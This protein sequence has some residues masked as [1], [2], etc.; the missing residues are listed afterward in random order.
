MKELAYYDKK[1][2]A[3]CATKTMYEKRFAEYKKNVKRINRKITVLERAQVFLQMVAKQT[4]EKLKFRIEPIVQLALDTCWDKEYEFAVDFEIKRNRTEASL[5]FMAVDKE[6]KYAVDPVEE[7]AGGAI[8]VASFAL[9]LAAWSLGKTEPVIVVDEPFKWLSKDLKFKA[10]ELMMELRDKLKLQFIM[11]THID[12]MIDI[13][14]R[15]FIVTKR[16]GISAVKQK[17]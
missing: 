12:D 3:A 15:V 9:R 17:V 13:S 6:I 11:V 5:N 16:Q 10:G 14:D 4:Q 2:N 8:D 1:L 7:D